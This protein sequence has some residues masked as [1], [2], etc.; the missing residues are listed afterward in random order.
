MV[1]GEVGHIYGLERRDLKAATGY[2]TAEWI[3]VFSCLARHVRRLWRRRRATGQVPKQTEGKPTGKYKLLQE[4]TTNLDKYC[5]NS[6]QV[7]LISDK[8]RTEVLSL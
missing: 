8:T 3:W 2:L 6:G 7:R 5:I 4:Y 1:N